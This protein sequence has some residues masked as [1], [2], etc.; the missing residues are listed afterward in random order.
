VPWGEAQG[1]QVGQHESRTDVT[2]GILKSDK[3]A[4][5][6]GAAWHKRSAQLGVPSFDA[7]NKGLC[8]RLKSQ[9]FVSSTLNAM[10]IQPQKPCDEVKDDVAPHLLQHASRRSAK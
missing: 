6:R 10:A 7:W 5:T 8:W 9:F 3:Q 4:K 1:V 2:G